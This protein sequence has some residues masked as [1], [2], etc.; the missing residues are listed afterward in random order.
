MQ[1]STIMTLHAP[2]VRFAL[3]VAI[4]A[5]SAG[6]N[7]LEQLRSVFHGDAKPPGPE[8][9]STLIVE[10]DPGKGI[11]VRLNDT[12]V[13]RRSPYRAEG[14]A[15]GEHQ[16][17]VSADGYHPFATPVVLAEKDTVT[18]TINL[19]RKPPPPKRE[20][21]KKA[22]PPP[23]PPEGPGPP[24][25]SGVEPITLKLATQPEFPLRVNGHDVVG[26][27]VVLKR[28]SGHIFAGPLQLKYRIGSSGLLELNLPDDGAE[29]F[30]DGQPLDGKRFP[31]HQGSIRLERRD[32][33]GELQVMW[34]RR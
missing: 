29:W 6:C 10:V 22:Q 33:A 34:L 24:L 25:P 13:A 32:A 3:F 11:E 14:M 9:D 20:T 26:K 4:L 18:L 7:V 1:L 12:L 23:K 2:P 15:A 27:S 17:V 30:R 31:L 28:V 16:L 5:A 8:G 21:P 19:R